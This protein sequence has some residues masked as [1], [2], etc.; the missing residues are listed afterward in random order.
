MAIPEI[1]L[2]DKRLWE[3]HRES[4]PSERKYFYADLAYELE[5][6][7]GEQDAGYFVL[8]LQRGIVLEEKYGFDS[9]EDANDWAEKQM[10]RFPEAYMDEE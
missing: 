4:S 2:R 1:D 7:V 9:A 3:Y 8:V 5:I 6:I 10:E